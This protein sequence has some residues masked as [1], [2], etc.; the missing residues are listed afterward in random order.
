MPLS[1]SSACR[2]EHNND[3][4]FVKTLAIKSIAQAVDAAAI[5]ASLVTKQ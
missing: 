3:V 5:R 1:L 4:A 2:Y